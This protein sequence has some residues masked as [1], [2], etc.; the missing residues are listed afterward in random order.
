[1]SNI[2]RHKYYTA[3]WNTAMKSL[4]CVFL[5]VSFDDIFTFAHILTFVFRFVHVI[6]LHQ[7]VMLPLFF[8]SAIPRPVGEGKA[9]TFPRDVR[10]WERLWVLR[11]NS[12]RPRRHRLRMHDWQVQ[13]CNLNSDFSSE[14]GGSCRY[15]GCCLDR[16]I[17]LIDTS[18]VLMDVFIK[19]MS[20][21]VCQI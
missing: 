9:K 11:H 20:V 14:C 1:M 19:S 12:Q 3:E 10:V 17:L 7:Y 2:E 6:I 16:S 18:V 21:D 13:L 8:V 15:P 5:H 4:C